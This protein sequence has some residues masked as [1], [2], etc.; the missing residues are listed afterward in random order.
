MEEKIT[1]LQESIATAEKALADYVDKANQEVAF[2]RG[3]INALQQAVAILTG[4]NEE[5]EGENG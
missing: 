1:T 3:Q 2:R 4:E 5:N